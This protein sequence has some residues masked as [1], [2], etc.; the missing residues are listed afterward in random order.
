MGLNDDERFSVEAA[1]QLA[2]DENP[3]LTRAEL[4]ER[5]LYAGWVD[6][7]GIE[8]AAVAKRWVLRDVEQ[9]DSVPSDEYLEVMREVMRFRDI[10]TRLVDHA[11]LTQE[12]EITLT[13]I[14]SIAELSKFTDELRHG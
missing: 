1:I 12:E 10:F 3:G 2:R 13:V 9:W 14:D 8:K 7:F 4:V 5:H 6:A 11:L